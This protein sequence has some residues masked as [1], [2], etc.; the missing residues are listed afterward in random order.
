MS[1]T[2]LSFSKYRKYVT[3]SLY[4]RLKLLF[5]LTHSYNY[6]FEKK[7]RML[8]ILKYERCCVICHKV[9]RS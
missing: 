8:L 9:I 1:K 6:K 5:K 3:K 7:R 4:I 2:D